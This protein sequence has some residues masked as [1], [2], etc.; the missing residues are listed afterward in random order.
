SDHLTRQSGYIGITVFGLLR[1]TARW[2]ESL[3]NH[4]SPLN[5][6]ECA[7]HYYLQDLDGSIPRYAKDYSPSSG[8]YMNP[9][10][11]STI[12]VY[13]HDSS[14]APVANVLIRQWGM[15]YPWGETD[16]TG[17]AIQEVYSCKTNLK[18]VDQLNQATVLDTIFFAEPGQS[19]AIDVCLTHS[20]SEDP[21]LQAP[22]GNFS[23]YPSVLRVN[24]DYT[25]HLNYDGKLVSAQVE[26][27]DLK[28]RLIGKQDY[29][30]D[31]MTWQVPK[32]ASGIYFVRLC[33]GSRNLGNSKLIVLK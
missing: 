11:R 30:N 31:G 3:T 27:Y 26:L 20:A 33:S 22:K 4:F 32:L 2:G 8:G 7:L 24:Q 18:I 6:T 9:S 14:G 25:L 13:C 17:H 5:G 1:D 23:I 16:V 10:A 28:G 21:V 19:Y 12:D 15:Y 29:T